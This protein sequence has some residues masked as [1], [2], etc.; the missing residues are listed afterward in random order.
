MEVAFKVGLEKSIVFVLV[1]KEYFGQR[2]TIGAKSWRWESMACM[3]EILSTLVGY[4][5]PVVK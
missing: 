4:Q 5:G 1:K 3:G 2:G